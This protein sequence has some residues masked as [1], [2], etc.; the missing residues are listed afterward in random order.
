MVNLGAKYLLWPRDHNVIVGDP[1]L[2]VPAP[3]LDAR[4]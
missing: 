1:E 4:G 3:A 2:S